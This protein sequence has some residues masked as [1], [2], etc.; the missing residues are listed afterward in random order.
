MTVTAPDPATV[1]APRAFPTVLA[2]LVV[3]N[4]EGWL[5]ECLAAL[6]AQT[7]PR[8]G[9]MAIDDGSDDGSHETLVRALGEGRVVRH[10]RPEGYARSV[11]AALALP[12]AAKADHVLLL[13]DDVAPGSVFALSGGDRRIE[14]HFDCGYT[15]AQVFA[16]VD[17]DV[18]CFEPM[19]APTDALRR[20]GYRE[21]AP[22]ESAVARFRIK[23]A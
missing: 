11:A 5:R 15:A 8:F 4:A 2:V 13:H 14:V 1:A 19:A 3:R 7:Y 23:V 9:V 18:V 21:V 12:A 22:G 16:P 20:G 17:D 6:A 10:D